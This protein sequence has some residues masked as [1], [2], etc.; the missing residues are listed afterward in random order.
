MLLWTSP[1]SIVWSPVP[2]AVSYHIFSSSQPAIGFDCIDNQDP[3]RT[4]VIF[5]DNSPPGILGEVFFKLVTAD[6]GVQQG[7]AGDGTC[8]ERGFQLVCP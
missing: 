7:P 8:S 6:D 1:T 3:D 2:G 5:I 4:D